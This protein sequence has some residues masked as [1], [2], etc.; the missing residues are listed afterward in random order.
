MSDTIWGPADVT[1]A[2]IGFFRARGIEARSRVPLERAPGMVRV[3]RVGGGPANAAQDEA[4]LVIEVWE[5]SQPAAFD[6]ARSLWAM[7]AVIDEGDQEAIPGLIT[8]SIVPDFPVQ[9]PDE[10]SPELDRAQFTVTAR[11]AFEEVSIP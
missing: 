5:S 8:Y 7:L 3:T 6:L 2:L 10:F 1:A 4:H 11:V 9:L